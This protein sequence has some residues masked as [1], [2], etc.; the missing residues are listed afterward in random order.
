MG[1]M[2][3]GGVL[4]SWRGHFIVQMGLIRDPVVAKRAELREHRLE[5]GMAP[6]GIEKNLSGN[7]Y[8]MPAFFENTCK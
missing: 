2:H 4:A 1:L 5:Y 7:G 8:A 6:T 3:K